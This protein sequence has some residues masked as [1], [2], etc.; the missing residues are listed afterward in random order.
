MQRILVLDE[1]EC[2]GNFI[3]WAGLKIDLMWIAEIYRAVILQ[4]CMAC[5]NNIFVQCW[6]DCNAAQ[7]CVRGEYLATDSCLSI[8]VNF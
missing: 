1:L 5:I 4:K 3:A 2:F 6:N 8:Y 7:N